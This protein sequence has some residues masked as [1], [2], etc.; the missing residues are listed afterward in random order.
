MAN[1]NGSVDLL[2][3]V[4]QSI[5][6]E[7]VYAMQLPEGASDMKADNAAFSKIYESLSKVN[8][9]K[10][11]NYLT[12][13]EGANMR[14]IVTIVKACADGVMSDNALKLDDIPKVAHMI[15]N[16]I[17]CINESSDVRD[18][19]VNLKADDV[20]GLVKAIVTSYLQYILPAT[21]YDQMM[22][23]VDTQFQ[24]I[25]L[26]ALPVIASKCGCPWFSFI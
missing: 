26:T 11:Y 16:I 1:V 10:I 12:A 3:R 4:A 7:V 25:Q 2:T 9:T 23:F 18:T 14:R 19:S 21:Q 5:A 6:Q 24:M 17:K 8:A 13:S 15:I 20:V 22:M